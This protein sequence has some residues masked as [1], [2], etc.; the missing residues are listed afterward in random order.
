MSGLPELCNGVHGRRERPGLVTATGSPSKG[1]GPSEA[2]LAVG[3]GEKALVGFRD[4]DP[5]SR[6]DPDRANRERSG[7]MPTGLR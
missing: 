5:Y 3:R 6:S 7:A 2:A 4:Q 1:A